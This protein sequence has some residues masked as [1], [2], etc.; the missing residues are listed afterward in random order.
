MLQKK[1]HET[2]YMTKIFISAAFVA[3][4]SPAFQVQ[5]NPL[6]YAQKLCSQIGTPI[7]PV[8]WANPEESFPKFNL[9]KKYLDPS[10]WTN[11]LA[12]AW[13][14]ENQ[15]IAATTSKGDQDF[16]Y[17][18]IWSTQRERINEEVLGRLLGIKDLKEV[19]KNGNPIATTLNDLYIFSQVDFDPTDRRNLFVSVFPINVP[20][21]NLSQQDSPQLYWEQSKPR[22]LNDQYIRSLEF[23]YQPN[24]RVH[25]TMV[26]SQEL[27]H[28]LFSQINWLIPPHG[29]LVKGSPQIQPTDLL[30]KLIENR[31]VQSPT[32]RTNP[33]MVYH[34]TDLDYRNV[35][36]L[37]QELVEKLNFSIADSTPQES[38]QNTSYRNILA[39][40]PFLRDEL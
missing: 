9:F 2:I 23:K 11:S 32:A 3:F 36:A 20:R 28:S 14:V 12:A 4:V 6:S 39:P 19:S 35:P 10:P 24:G 30:F 26:V 27:S 17:S 7:K 29:F 8:A 22:I 40:K 13:S 15:S 1:K 38:T 33:G 21:S 16:E 25:V 5:A 37:L 18:V 31:V 34:F